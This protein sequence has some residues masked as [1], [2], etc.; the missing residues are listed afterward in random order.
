LKTK[1]ELAQKAYDLA[2]EYDKHF[3]YCPQCVLAAVKETVDAGITDEIIRSTFPAAGGGALLGVGTCG[4]LL[5]GILALGCK[6]GRTRD[7]FGKN[8]SKRSLFAAKELIIRFQEKYGGVSCNDVQNKFEGCTFDM[9][10]EK[11]SKDFGNTH[12]KKI[13]CPQLAGDVAKWT[14]ELL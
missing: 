8:V 6:S 5:G 14:V 7:Q 2:W 4:A 11:A 9:W 10:N 3:G 13:I 12:C 1:T